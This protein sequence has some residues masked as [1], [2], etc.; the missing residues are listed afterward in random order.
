MG[1]AVHSTLAVGER[2]TTT[3]IQ[4]RYL[5]AITTD[6]GEVHAEGRV[7]RVGG[8]VAAAE[9]WLYPASDRERTLAHGTTG[10]LIM[11]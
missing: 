2:Y 4:V 10:C 9:G 5:G 11:R 6:T 7:V 8:R 3:D 1:C